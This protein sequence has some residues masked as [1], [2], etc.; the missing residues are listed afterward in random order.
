V[1]QIYQIENLLR[2]VIGL[3]S[4]TIG[5]STI[6]R[7]VRLRMRA[8]NLGRQDD[9]LKLLQ[10]SPAEWDLLVE[11]VVVAETW[12]FREKEAFHCMVKMV[13]DEWLPAHP[14][15]IL[16]VLSV[17]CSTGEE[18]YSIAMAL[19]DAGVPEARFQI[20]AIDI[21]ASALVEA[22]RAVYGNN[23]F[24]GQDFEFRA[25]YFQPVPRGY[26]LNPAVKKQVHFQ[27]GNLLADHFLTGPD[28]YD[29]VFCRNLLIYLDGD[30]QQKVLVK[31]RRLLAPDGLLFVGPAELPL[32]VNNG[33]AA[34]KARLS[35][36]CRKVVSPRKSPRDNHAPKNAR[37][38]G[39]LER[40][41][42]GIA[43]ARELHGNW[44]AISPSMQPHPQLADLR[45]AR[46]LAQAGC[47][48]EAAAIC[49]AHMR[50]YGVS[51]EAF[52]LL[53]LIRDY[54]GADFQA[55]EF[56]RKALYLQP[57]HYDA[58]IQWASL[59]KRNGND[60]H[61]QILQN[62]AERLKNQP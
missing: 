51:A 1:N 47:L 38:A 23:S 44:N 50:L 53:G 42:A 7:A 54:S 60:A 22:Q 26:A 52:Y 62:R 43:T 9:Y 17:P 29:F 11:T 18:P 46:E 4:G 41:A 55:T 34:N 10:Q 25:R 13:V 36:A 32:A 61:A 16:R 2:Q 20:E 5:T 3:D 56:Y 21:S 12:F 30:S 6:E 48:H 45:E 8:R 24:R 19:M 15:R 37:H 58:L 28:S 40:P 31:V 33:F 49:E 39:I 35:F 14:H 27:R 59:A 57:T